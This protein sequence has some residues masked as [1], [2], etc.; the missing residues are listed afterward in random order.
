MH[1]AGFGRACGRGYGKPLEICGAPFQHGGDSDSDKREPIDHWQVKRD[2]NVNE[3]GDVYVTGGIVQ[4][5]PELEDQ[6]RSRV[7]GRA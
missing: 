1:G 2:V 5:L 3:R 6:S 7:S 4:A